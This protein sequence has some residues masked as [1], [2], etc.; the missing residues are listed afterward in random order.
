MS[1]AKHSS[2]DSYTSPAMDA[3][4]RLERR[5]DALFVAA[6][7]VASAVEQRDKGCPSTAFWDQR[8][9]ERAQDLRRVVDELTN[10]TPSAPERK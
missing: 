8:L 1:E 6:V 7:R 4:E 2:A 3:L 10:R 5:W 9:L